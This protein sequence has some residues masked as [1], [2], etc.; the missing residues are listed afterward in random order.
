VTENFAIIIKIVIFAAKYKVYN[1]KLMNI[2]YHNSAKGIHLL[3]AVILLFS[4]NEEI[5]V[6]DDTNVLPR[7]NSTWNIYEKCQRN[8]D[9]SVTYQAIPWGG[10]VATFL[11][12]NMPMDL[13]GY[14]SITVE[15]DKPTTVSTQILVAE[16]FKTWGKRGISKL[17]CNFDGQDVSSVD[18]IVLQAGDSCTL[19]ITQAYLTPNDV[20]WESKMIWEGNCAFGDW[21]NGFVIKPEQFK[22]AYEGDKLEFFFKTDQSNPEVTYWLFKTI[23]SGTSNTLEGNDNE[24]NDWG[25]AFVAPEGHIYRIVLTAN[26]VENLREKGLF[27]NGYCVNVT[28]CNL[29]SRVSPESY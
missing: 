1:H 25:C 2:Y 4:C 19:N 3:F 20:S 15:F 5:K 16:N 10:L 22:T 29:I 13:S 24:L 21:E 28:Q 14:E 26:D 7:F 17:T 18:E 11:D 23:Y 8:D 6:E 27:V 9:G 12:K